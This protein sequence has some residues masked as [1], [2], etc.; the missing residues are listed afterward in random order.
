[1]DIKSSKSDTKLVFGVGT[2]D[3]NYKV[4]IKNNKSS[5]PSWI[6]PFY[7]KWVNLLMRCY[8]ESYKA[9]RKSYDGATVCVEWHLFSTFKSW[10]EIQDWEGKDL[11]KDL[12]IRGNK[13]YSPETCVFISIKINSFITDR[14]RNKGS[15][16]TGVSF[17][18]ASD[19]LRSDCRNPF[20]NKKEFL[21]TFMDELEAH[22]AWLTRKDEL[23]Q[24][25]AQDESDKRISD[26]L[27]ERYK[28]SVELI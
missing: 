19:R 14:I 22:R 26:A 21:G 20:T 9:K 3:A 24:M 18:K 7:R 1:M 13:V 17:H 11:D 28:Q 25:L 2:N 15:Y 4:Q 6:C 8:C 12:L 10:M 27:I 5:Q 23:A 16:A